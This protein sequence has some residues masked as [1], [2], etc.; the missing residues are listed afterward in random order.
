MQV[1]KGGSM[2]METTIPDNNWHHYAIVFANQ[3][4]I[5]LDAQIGDEF[6]NPTPANLSAAPAGNVYLF[7][8]NY[9][10]GSEYWLDELQAWD[11]NLEEA[12]TNLPWQKGTYLEG[13]EADLLFNYRFDMRDDKKVFNMTANS[14]GDTY[15]GETK[16]TLVWE[17]RPEQQ[18]SLAYKTLTNED[19][20]YTLKAI[21]HRQ[22][23]G[24]TFTLVP[25]KAVPG[26]PDLFH[27]FN[28]ATFALPLVYHK[29]DFGQYLKVH[30]IIDISQMPI[31]G[32][33]YYNT[34]DEAGV[35]QRIPAPEGISM[36]IGD[37]AQLETS[38]LSNNYG[39][40]LLFSDMGDQIFKVNNPDILSHSTGAQSLYFDGK[41]S[42]AK[43]TNL[44]KVNENKGTWTGWIKKSDASNSDQTIMNIGDGLGLILSGNQNLLV[45]DLARNTQLIKIENVLNTTDW[46]FF[47]LTY[48]G[49][50]VTLKAGNSNPII[51]G[52]STS[53]T[54]TDLLLGMQA[55]SNAEATSFTGYLDQLEFR[56]EVYSEDEIAKIK[57][58]E[59][60]DRDERHLQLSY[61]FAGQDSLYRAISRGPNA[62]QRVMTLHGAKITQFTSLNYTKDYKTK[63][64]PTNLDESLGANLEEASY[65]TTVLGPKT[66]LDFEITNRF[67]FT[68]YIQTPCGFG[69][70]P[71]EGTITRTDLPTGFT[72]QKEIKTGEFNDDH[73]V[74]HVDDLVPGFYKV[75]LENQ[76][77]GRELEN[78][79][80]IKID[81]ANYVYDFEWKNP[82]EGAIEVYAASSTG[83]YDSLL[84]PLVCPTTN[85]IYELESGIS[86]ELEL[87]A[88]EMYGTNQCMVDNID[89]T[90]SGDLGTSTSYSGEIT[91]EGTVRMRFTAGSPNYSDP[92][93]PRKFTVT[94]TRTGGIV[95]QFN[96]DL[97]A[98]VTGSEMT[99]P[100]NF[101]II[102]PDIITVLHDPPG[103]NSTI[104][105]N[106]GTTITKNTSHSVA[107]G[108]ESN[109]GVA[110]GNDFNNS[111]LIGGF[112]GG[113]INRL[114][115]SRIE[116][117]ISA[118]LK[119]TQGGEWVSEH[120]STLTSSI[121]TNGGQ[122]IVGEDADVFI[123]RGQ[124]MTIGTGRT[125][126]VN[127]QCVPELKTNRDIVRFDY[128]TPFYYTAT[129]I[130]G[131]LQ[132]QL[133]II[134]N[135]PNSKPEDISEA[136]TEYNKW[137]NILTENTER[138]ENI[139]NASSF[140][141]AFF[142]GHESVSD[143]NDFSISGSDQ[144]SFGGKVTI[145][146]EVNTSQSNQNTHSGS[147]TIGTGYASKSDIAVAGFLAR[148]TT[149]VDIS[150]QHSFSKAFTDGKVRGY[151]IKLLDDEVFDHFSVNWKRDPKYGTPMFK[152]FAG[153]TKCPYESGT[154]NR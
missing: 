56:D 87:K 85:G 1:H 64:V 111:V 14:R 91:S 114:L 153:Q 115:K 146:L 23:D 66:N 19:G 84:A 62:H 94:L 141:D 123:G 133:E 22:T 18:V 67:G 77:N 142:T 42:Y 78:F 55:E 131:V 98:Y 48:D 83:A 32:Q 102:N 149:N 135:D 117:E 101:T 41:E 39:N 136:E 151:S 99:N 128:T 130:K 100:P 59:V 80:T 107:G 82:L 140:T 31:S 2:V 30:D 116:V 126:E 132:N 34:P 38:F 134:K 54:E 52:A 109:F 144:F 75:K 150:V 74:F 16:G 69:A 79:Q 53:I 61:S 92:T 63:Y 33:F 73:T 51:V 13:D 118:N 47:A 46:V 43:V 88:F 12:N 37:A 10:T 50:Q 147:T 9:A 15:T 139:E 112:V 20:D 148:L 21:D 70:G 120:N 124:I 44:P 24:E 138:I 5:Y 137:M 95:E 4:T 90:A 35:N 152:T 81:S 26:Y 143:P 40:Y 105:L 93:T 110:F 129:G 11:W 106:E 76:E 145:G 122:D 8:L 121:T 65:S 96:A 113:V 36:M 27:D 86:Y 25:F 127:A 71:W 68:G 29:D 3:G 89:Y 125:V 49:S 104:T 119:H 6:N 57:T 60:I 108:I 28:P 97:Q 17:T 72:F 7:E 45:K 58:G 154:E 103:D